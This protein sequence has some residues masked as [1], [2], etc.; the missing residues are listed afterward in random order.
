MWRPYDYKFIDIEDFKRVPA[1]CQIR[2]DLILYV[3]LSRSSGD[4]YIW[5]N[6]EIFNPS[7]WGPNEPDEISDQGALFPRYDYKFV[8]YPDWYKF[9]SLCQIRDDCRDVSDQN[10]LI[11]ASKN[12][13][14][15]E[16]ERLVECGANLDIKGANEKTPLMWACANGHQRVVRYLLQSGANVEA[17]NWIGS[18]ALS[19]A[20]QNG[21]PDVA[22]VLLKY[23]ANINTQQSQGL[24]PLMYA[25]RNCRIAMIKFLLRKGADKSILDNDN[26]TAKQIAQEGGCFDG[27]RRLN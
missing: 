7:W 11:L 26:K 22:R 17:T 24:T 1:L 4:E 25:A 5:G 19:Y 23:H 6:G 12:G 27:V 20:A 3:S 13:N 21:R 16:V 18:T 2:G 9:D 15:D 8:D 10:S 14:L